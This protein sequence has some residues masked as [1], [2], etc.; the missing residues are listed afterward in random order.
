MGF[1]IAGAS[2]AVTSIA[3][4]SMAQDKG[5]QVQV[6]TTLENFFQ[7]GTQPE[8][9]PL[10]FYPILPSINCTYCH[11][12]YD[13]EAAPYDTWVATLKAQAARDPV[14][15]AALTISNQ[16]ADN[17]GEYCIRCHSPRA[18]LG[19]RS[20]SA[21]IDSF[22][23]DDFDGINCNFCH[24]VVN[25]VLG[26]D[27]AVGYP[28]NEVI[29]NPDPTPDVDIIKALAAEGLLPEHIGNGRY[30]VDPSDERRGPFADIPDNLHGFT[31]WGE[32]INLITSP[33]HTKSEHC[34]TCHDLGNP[35]FMRQKDGTYL[36]V[37]P[38]QEHP[39]QNPYDMFP[40]Q[41]TYS[42]WL[43]STFA[44]DGV[45]FKDGRF[46]GNHPTGVMKS[47]QDC[48]MPRVEGGGCAFWET[49]PFFPRPDI[50]LHGFNGGNTW[51]IGAIRDMLGEEA[52]F[53]G[54]TQERVDAAVARTIDMLRAASDMELTQVDDQLQVRVINYSGH[55]LPTG[56][57]EGRRMWLNV[58]FLDADDNLIAEHGAYDFDEATLDESSTKV[59][60][61][62]HGMDENIA[63]AT[64]L[65]EGKSF[66]LALNNVILSDNRIPPI[67]FTNAAFEEVQAEPVAYTYEDGQ[68]WDDTLYPVPASAAKAVVT[69]YYQTTTR[70]YMEFL[71]DANK[72]DDKGQIAYDAWVARGRSA[73]VD[74]DTAIIELAPAGLVGDLNGDGHVDGADLG[75][76]L[77]AWGSPGG[78]ADLN[79]D[80]VVDGA[81]LGVQLAN[82]TG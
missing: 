77:G 37:P 24:R 1:A 74:M 69:L 58:K 59:Y 70:E 45:A 29:P 5:G 47:C 20:S 71:R 32:P 33:F 39:T 66:H 17:S 2:L 15:Q 79:H 46:G 53:Y 43:K 82:W 31:E 60:K 23:P 42:E 78:P 21:T 56:Y 75:L 67:G 76:L 49:P 34:G 22:E 11:S 64:N 35:V 62:D 4:R 38:G 40:E 18:W 65:P 72:T 14:W 16:D 28:P 26:P 6:P 61:A 12:D 13:M 36:P 9:N 48:H 80:G 51:V 8:E 10:L 25:P 3:Q 63:K 73:P 30:V 68:H 7:P 52:D 57:P 19:G 55:K 44:T 81:D 27:S 41:R 50:P 54:L